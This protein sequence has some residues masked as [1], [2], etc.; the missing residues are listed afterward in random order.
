M[1]PEAD[2][3]EDFDLLVRLAIAGKQ[4]YFLP[5]FLMEYRFHGGQ[6]SLKQ[7]LHYLK[8]K[9][10]CI[11]DYHFDD[12]KLEEKRLTKLAQTKQDL[13]LRLIEEGTTQKGRKLLQESKQ[14][15]GSSRRSNLGILISYFPPNLRQLFF[16]VFRKLRTKDYTE[17]VRSQ[18]F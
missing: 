16:Q 9:L 11:N 3:C 8:S 17:K 13:G 18:T 12:Q 4:G 15:L 6:T 2:G 14:V 1:R 7:N 5:E 10:F